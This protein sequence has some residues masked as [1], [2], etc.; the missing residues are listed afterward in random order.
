MIK[1]I[2]MVIVLAAIALVIWMLVPVVCS[3][4]SV[5]ENTS[6]K[7][8]YQYGDISFSEVLTTEESS[9]VAQILDGKVKTRYWGSTPSCGYDRNIAIEVNG[10]RYALACDKCA[11]LK[12]CG[13][14]NTYIELTQEERN[15]LE[16][17]F[18]A[19][20]GKFPCV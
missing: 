12:V 13:S 1:K 20:G 19:R 16:V 9:A 14:F 4:V 17:I 15:I 2:K 3:K 7:V 5:S 10:I 18:S 8:V 11:T 6:C